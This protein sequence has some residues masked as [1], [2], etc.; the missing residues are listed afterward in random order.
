[1]RAPELYFKDFPPE[2][3]REEL[4]RVFRTTF[5]T[6]EGQIA[7]AYILD[8]LSFLTYPRDAEM[9]ARR[10]YATELLHDRLGYTDLFAFIEAMRNSQGKES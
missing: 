3:Q 8:D 1:M 4:Q 10:N 2:R 7:L 5:A 9:V 6:P